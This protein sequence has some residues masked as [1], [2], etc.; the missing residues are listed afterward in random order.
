ML[1]G[2]CNPQSD[3]LPDSCHQALKVGEECTCLSGTW[4]NLDSVFGILMLMLLFF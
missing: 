3:V 4:K 1:I 2:A